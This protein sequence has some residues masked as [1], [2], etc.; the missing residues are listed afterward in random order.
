MILPDWEIEALIQ[1]RVLGVDPYVPGN[2]QPASLDVC[3]SEDFR[4]FNHQAEIIDPRD[5][6]PISHGVKLAD[7]E[8]F[9]LHPGEFALAST[10]ESFSFPIDLAGQLGGKSSLG[11]LGL[12]I[13]ATAGFFDPGF[14]GQATLELS[15]VARLPIR[16]YKG[17]AV[18]Q[19]VFLRMSSPCRTPYGS[20]GLGSKYMGQNGPVESRSHRNFTEEETA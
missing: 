6:T 15:N 8:W 16:L 7:G 2:L 19:M 13:H 5:P 9:V 14:A 12:Q 20:E 4:V 17:M 11:R 10:V 3:L 1:S 18:A